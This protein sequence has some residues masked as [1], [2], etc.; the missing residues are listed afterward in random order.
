M[1]C[2]LLS[3]F[4][5]YLSLIHVQ[6]LHEKYVNHVVV[7]SDMWGNLHVCVCACIFFFFLEN[8]SPEGIYKRLASCYDQGL[9]QSDTLGSPFTTTRMSSDSCMLNL[10]LPGCHIFLYFLLCLVK[11]PD[12]ESQLDFDLKIENKEKLLGTAW[13]LRNHNKN[14]QFK[15]FS[16]WRH[17]WAGPLLRASQGCPGGAGQG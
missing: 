8:I 14:G 5:M 7:H 16:G 3:F 6:T 10:L 9:L 12:S 15:H 17:R 4:I 11:Y 2:W 1:I 13:V